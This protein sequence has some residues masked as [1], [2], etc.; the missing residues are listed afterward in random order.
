MNLIDTA[1][2]Y[3]PEVSE[4]LIAEALNP[5][6]QDLIVATKGGT[7]PRLPRM[8]GGWPTRDDPA[9]LP[10]QPRRVAAERSVYELT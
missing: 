5:Y 9:P 4:R 10:A 1:H 2:A 6:P 3:G 8:G 7:A